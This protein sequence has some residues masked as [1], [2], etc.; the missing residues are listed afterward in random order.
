MSCSFKL[1]G[2]WDGRQVAVQL[3]FCEMLLPEIKTACSILIYFPSSFLSLSVV[4][5]HVVHPYNSV[6]TAIAWKIS[7]FIL[8][9]RLDFHMILAFNRCLV[10][11]LSVDEI[12]LLRYVNWSTNFRNL[13]L[14]VHFCP[15]HTYSVLLAFMQR[16]NASC[17][18]VLRLS[19]CMKQ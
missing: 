16:V 19:W 8:L 7:H 3:L 17:C 1:S 12:L 6:D 18:S 2:W 15:K 5:I 11:S 14:M 4:S 9:D 10:T 13:P